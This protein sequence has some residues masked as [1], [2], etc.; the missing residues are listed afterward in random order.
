M[1]KIIGYW[2]RP[3]DIEGFEAHY[4]ST[5]LPKANAV[6]GLRRLVTMRPEGAFEGGEPEHYRVA[7]MVFDDMDALE[8]A[9]ESP[10][11]RAMRED[12]EY[13]HETFG[14]SVTGELGQEVIFG[15]QDGE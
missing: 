4:A 5:H 12:A 6:P 14:A 7:E 1:L 11:Y 3:D 13:M 2:T 15:S 10:E 8:R 9:A